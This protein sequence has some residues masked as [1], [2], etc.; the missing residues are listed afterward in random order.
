MLSDS[1]KEIINQS[2]QFGRFLKKPLRR[3]LFDYILYKFQIIKSINEGKITDKLTPYVS[4]IDDL[5][6]NSDLVSLARSND[7]IFT[8]ILTRMI[9]VFEQIEKDINITG[10]FQKEDLELI[11][12]ENYSLDYFF[13]QFKKN[14]KIIELYNPGKN[15]NLQFFRDEYEKLK[16]SEVKN[17]NKQKQALKNEILQRWEANLLKKKHLTFLKRIDEERE[18]LCKILYDQIKKLKKMMKILQPFTNECGRLWDLS[19]GLW[20]TTDFSILEYYAQL[21]EKE[22]S[23]QDLAE[24]LGRMHQAEDELEE[25]LINE[26]VFKP[27]KVIDHAQKSELVGTHESNDINYL[28]PIEL[29]NLDDPTTELI[30]YQK[31]AE[32]KLLTYQ[33]LGHNLGYEEEQ[34]KK[35]AKVAKKTKKGPIIICVDTSGSMHGTPEY[36]AKTL[37]FAILRIA[38]LEQRS[39]Y[40]ISFSTS[41][42]TLELTDFNKSLPKLIEFLTFSF[43]GGTDAIPALREAVK[44]I[45][46]K[47]YEKSD[48]L[49]ISDFIMDNIDSNTENQILKCK[50]NDTKFHS[51]VVSSVANPNS[52]KIFDNNWIYDSGSFEEL[53]PVLKNFKAI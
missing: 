38:L 5:S 35:L 45:Q 22:P 30:F 53:K 17:V 16:V 10:E 41:I 51:L 26:T 7:S 42:H 18:K 50:E 33:F 2:I 31:F 1:I 34:R 11:K 12:M 44:K 49:M 3:R 13:R 37:C 47:K 46:E 19:K 48:V 27:I 23:I 39:C 25:E 4:F 28:L 52:L 43:Y 6:E 21:V 24:I 9:R 32:K 40:L 14:M 20:Q 8:D 15:F 29:T 36:I